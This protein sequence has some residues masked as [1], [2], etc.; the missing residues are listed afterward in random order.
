MDD[1]VL[2]EFKD[3][4]RHYRVIKNSHIKKILSSCKTLKYVQNWMIKNIIS[5]V[6]AHSIL[7]SILRKG[8][9]IYFF[10]PTEKFNIF[11]GSPGPFRRSAPLLSA[12]FLLT[13][14]NNWSI[15]WL[16]TWISV[17][18]IN[19]RVEQKGQL[20][21]ARVTLFVPLYCTL[22]QFFALTRYWPQHCCI[23]SNVLDEVA[24]F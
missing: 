20:Q 18:F 22:I 4:L 10:N 24:F 19:C 15:F 21:S 8:T 9:F 17:Y 16:Y 6:A 1:V 23:C 11:P 12:T 3:D 14:L 7:L 13:L 2:N 5:V